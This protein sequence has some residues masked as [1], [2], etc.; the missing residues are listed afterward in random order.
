MK[1]FKKLMAVALAGVMALTVLTGCAGTVNKKD[2][3]AYLNDTKALAEYDVKTIEAGDSALAKEALSKVKTYA[4]NHANKYE[5][6]VT[7][8]TEALR[9]LS[10]SSEAYRDVAGIIKAIVPDKTEDAYYLAYAIVPELKSKEMQNQRDYMIAQEL[11]DNIV[12]LNGV[13]ENLGDKAVASIASTKI[14]DD[15]FVVVVFVQA[16]K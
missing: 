13:D 10:Y 6:E 1:M 14:G 7:Y 15:T 8:A 4:E 2:A 11:E 5:T 3:I 16:K 12:E 9:S